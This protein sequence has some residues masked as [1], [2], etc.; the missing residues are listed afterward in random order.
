MS[1][2]FKKQEFAC[3]CCGFGDATPELYE[4]L[5]ALRFYTGRPVMVLSG[6]RCFAQN[7]RVKGAKNSQHMWGTAADVV[8]DGW[9][10]DEIAALA[11]ERVPAFRNGGIGRY[12]RFTHLDVRTTGRARWTGR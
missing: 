2:H 4:A 6:Y 12:P 11:A 10:P 5:E 7:K 1:K 3:H 8:V 9:S